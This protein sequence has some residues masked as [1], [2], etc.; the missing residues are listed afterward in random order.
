MKYCEGEKKEEKKK[1][2]LRCG[3]GDGYLEISI[4]RSFEGLQV[5]RPLIT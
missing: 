1:N 3:F 5:R 4:C 2:L